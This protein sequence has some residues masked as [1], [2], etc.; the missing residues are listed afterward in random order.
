MKHCGVKHNFLLL[1]LCIQ[2]VFELA[3]VDEQNFGYFLYLKH[4]V[5]IFTTFDLVLKVEF[6]LPLNIVMKSS[7]ASPILHH[8]TCFI[9]LFNK[10]GWSFHLWKCVLQVVMKVV[11]I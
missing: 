3:G 9:L 8:Q 7:A 11:Q 10:E 6:H 2:F 5:F 1:Q 4:L